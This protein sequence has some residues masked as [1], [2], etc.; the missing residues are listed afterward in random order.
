MYIFLLKSSTLLMY[1][2]LADNYIFLLVFLPSSQ[3]KLQ[4]KMLKEMLKE[5]IITRTYY[6]INNTF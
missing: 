5:G 2:S 1:C 4:M 3:V 6:I